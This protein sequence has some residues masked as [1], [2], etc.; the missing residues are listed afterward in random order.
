MVILYSHQYSHWP[1]VSRPVDFPADAALVREELHAAKI[2]SP[3]LDFPAER[4]GEI[5]GMSYH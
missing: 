4:R 2:Q 1:R 5:P 3:N